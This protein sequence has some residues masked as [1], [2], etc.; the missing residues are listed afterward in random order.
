MQGNE[1]A[2]FLNAISHINKVMF[3][4]LEVERFIVIIAKRWLYE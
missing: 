2:K 4:V 3:I 1:T